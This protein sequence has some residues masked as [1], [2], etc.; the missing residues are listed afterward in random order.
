MVQLFVFVCSQASLA[1]QR[2][3]TQRVDSSVHSA[4]SGGVV[5]AGGRGHGGHSL[6][7]RV[8]AL[9]ALIRSVVIV[10]RSGRRFF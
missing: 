6:V 9:V 1:E 10:S 3:D 2:P 7:V 8:V 5:A 4:G